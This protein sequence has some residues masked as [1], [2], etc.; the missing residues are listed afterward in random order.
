LPSAFRAHENGIS[1]TFTCPLDGEIAGKAANHLVQCWNYRYGPGYGSPEYS[2][3]HPDVPGHDNLE[4]AGAHLTSDKRTLFLDIP[5]LQ[6]VNQLH[7]HL[8][9]NEGLP[10][11]VFATIH[12]LAAP[13]TGYAEY[14]SVPK[15]IAA[16]PMLVDLARSTK[17][18][19]NPWK[20]ELPGAR[21]V[22]IDA[23]KNLSFA[24]REFSSHPGETIR[25]VFRNPDVVPHNWLLVKP[26]TLQRVGDLANKLISAPDAAVRQYIPNSD[27]VLAYTD[28]VSPNESAT[29]Y[30]R[31]PMEKNR[32]PFLCA[33]P[34]HWMVMNGVLTVE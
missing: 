15:Q 34:G 11:D 28:V 13:Y 4:V 18:L 30:F 6:P 29:I 31:V 33:F 21:I 7:M 17:A 22:T 10:L 27:D 3:R 26:G 24:P 2:T 25:L 16:H 1:I 12:R 8:R 14:K 19:P 9:V 5:D 20:R 23:G 32:Y